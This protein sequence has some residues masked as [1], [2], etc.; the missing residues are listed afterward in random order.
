MTTNSIEL[1]RN[2]AVL[3]A[4]KQYKQRNQKLQ[5][6]LS[7]NLSQK[8]HSQQYM[9]NK[10]NKDL[11]KDIDVQSQGSAYNRYADSKPQPKSMA[12]QK[13]TTYKSSVSD[14]GSLD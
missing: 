7:N 3:D 10:Q 13:T 9:T 4:S 14:K 11:I 5:V 12:K 8:K 1:I 6:S 2:G